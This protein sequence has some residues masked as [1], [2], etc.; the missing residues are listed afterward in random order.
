MNKKSIS[1]EN[2]AAKTLLVIKKTFY[3][4]LYFLNKPPWSY[5]ANF[6]FETIKFE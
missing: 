6:K 2:T 1:R 4:T 3:Y 5:G